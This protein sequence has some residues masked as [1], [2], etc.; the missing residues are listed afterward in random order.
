[1]LMEAKGLV[2]C[3]LSL[4]SHKKCFVLH[5]GLG[6]QV[7]CAQREDIKAASHTNKDEDRGMGSFYV[8]F[9]KML[10]FM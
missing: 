1:M 5:T 8:L 6:H 2:V 4:E 7:T 9:P 10:Y 3:I